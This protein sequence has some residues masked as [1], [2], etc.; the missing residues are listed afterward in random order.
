VFRRKVFTIGWRGETSLLATRA[1]EML[2][3]ERHCALRLRNLHVRDDRPTLPVTEDQAFF[4]EAMCS[5]TL[6][7]ERN[8]RGW[9]SVA[10][11]RSDAVVNIPRE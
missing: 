11:V 10:G 6:L 8:A 4:A 3:L 1:R 5:R 7:D 9:Q 2:G